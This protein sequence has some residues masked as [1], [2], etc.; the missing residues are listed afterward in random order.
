V[1]IEDEVL[2]FKKSNKTG[3]WWI[4][5]PF[6]ANGNNKLKR[7]TLLPCTYGDYLCACNQEIPERWMK[8]RRKNEL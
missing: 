3:R 7:E 8:A 4:I 6:F 1:P 2:V 5:L